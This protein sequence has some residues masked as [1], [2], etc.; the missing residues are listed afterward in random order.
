MLPAGRSGHAVRA[1]LVG[2]PAVQ[3]PQCEAQHMLSTR[4]NT[5]SQGEVSLG[6]VR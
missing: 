2:L 6:K 3:P 1:G 5:T 4:C